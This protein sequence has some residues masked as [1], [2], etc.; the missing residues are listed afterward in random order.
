MNSIYQR[1]TNQSI[2]FPDLV[3]ECKRLILRVS[4]SSELN[5]LSRRLDRICQQHR[6]TRD[7]TLESLRFALTEVI[8]CFPVYRTYIS[9][10]Q[11]AVDEEDRRQILV[12]IEDAERRNPAM[13]GSIFISIA[14]IL[15]LEDPGGLSAEQ[16]AERR[17]FVMRFQQ[18]TG[19]VMAK[20]VEDTAFYRQFPLASLNEVGGDPQIFGLDVKTFHERIIRRSA[21]WPYNLMASTT[22][23]TKRSEDLRARLNI[24]SE[25]PDEWAAALRRWRPMNE[26]FT[27]AVDGIVTPDCEAEYLLYQTLVGA[28]PLAGLGDADQHQQFVQRIQDYMEKALREAKVRTSWIN[29][30]SAY[31]NAI[32]NFVAVA[33]RRTPDNEF[34]TDIETFSLN[35]SDAGLW[36]SLSQTVLKLTCPGVPDI[37]QGSE[38]WNFSLVDPDNRRPVDYALRKHLLAELPLKSMEGREAWLGEATG[39]LTDGRL[40]LFVNAV[41]ARFRR[42]NPDFFARATYVPLEATGELRDHVLAFARCVQGKAIVVVV[43]RFLVKLGCRGKIPVGKDVWGD[44]KVKVGELADGSYHDL[45]SGTMINTIREREDTFL[46]VSALFS[47]LPVSL[48]VS[49]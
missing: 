6:H 11:A 47:T 45:L 29:P 1:F 26:P 18:L 16:T 33:L 14:S 5:V 8:A 34:L 4:L 20:G 7:L 19:P 27:T 2:P 23:D 13:S 43:S 30:N 38:L 40:K 15:L 39:T 17:L 10:T 12:A 37:Y 21:H 9:E 24:L 32:R 31:D 49:D 35:I 48:L 22:H 44:L 46:P 41:I 28:W 3:Y 42:D 36:N 25:I